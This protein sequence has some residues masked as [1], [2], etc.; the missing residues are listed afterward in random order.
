MRDNQT[1]RR[2]FV[3]GAGAAAALAIWMGG[4]AM[5]AADTQPLIISKHTDGA[6][7]KLGILGCGNRSKAHIAALNDVPEIEVAALCDVV[8]HKMDQRAKLI[9]KKS[10]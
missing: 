8:E 4:K 1:T 9:T 6:P 10:A 3:G 7:Y 2:E 5:A